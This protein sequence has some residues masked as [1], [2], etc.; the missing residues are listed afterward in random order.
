MDAV[1]R[2]LFCNWIEACV[3]RAGPT[4]FLLASM[5]CITVVLSFPQ[6]PESPHGGSPTWRRSTGRIWSRFH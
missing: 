4:V 2:R 3:H 6:G 5:R 1:D